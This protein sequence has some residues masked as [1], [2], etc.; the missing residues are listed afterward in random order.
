[1]SSPSTTSVN[2]DVMHRILPLIHD[3][4]RRASLCLRLMRDQPFIKTPCCTARVCFTCKT[5]GHH[6]GTPCSAMFVKKEA[7]AHCPGCNLTLAKGDGC[8]WV[9]CFCGYGFDWILTSMIYQWSQLTARQVQ[10]VKQ[11]VAS[12]IQLRRLR[13]KVLPTLVRYVRVQEHKPQLLAVCE[14]LRH[15][16]LHT[17]FRRNVLPQM[18]ARV[19]MMD[20]AKQ[21]KYMLVVCNYLLGRAK[22][23]IYSKRLARELSIAVVRRTLAARPQQKP[24]WLKVCKFLRDKRAARQRPPAMDMFAG[25]D[26]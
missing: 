24:A 18:M 26:Y 8:N 5:Y 1:M 11:C 17:R 22:R 2:T 7:I 16:R 13:K 3:V 6:E 23:V 14:F 25:A 15:Q 12:Y 4:E 9:T 20:I 19:I 21:K 10:V